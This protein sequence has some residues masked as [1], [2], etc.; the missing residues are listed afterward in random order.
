MTAVRFSLIKV[1]RFLLVNGGVGLRLQQ[2]VVHSRKHRK[3]PQTRLPQSQVTLHFTVSPFFQVA[4]LLSEIIAFV[5]GMLCV[6][7]F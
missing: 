5:M 2:I 3:L 6:A 1:E 4:L 7:Q